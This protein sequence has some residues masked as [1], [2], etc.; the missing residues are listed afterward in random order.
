MKKFYK[1]LL[2]ISS[3]GLLTSCILSPGKKTSNEPSTTT[4]SQPTES[5][6]TTTTQDSRKKYEFHT[7]KSYLPFDNYGIHVS[8][9]ASGYENRD[10]IKDAINH[11]VGF[12]LVNSISA[13]DCTILTDDGTK[14]QEHLH[15]CVGTGSTDGGI[16]FNVSIQV[17]KIVVTVIPYYKTPYTVDTDATIYIDNDKFK[18]EVDSES[19]TQIESMYEKT[20]DTSVSSFTLSNKAEKQRFYLESVTL[21]Y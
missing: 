5:T 17:T 9:E 6:S 16:T 8:D 20:Y 10:A 13:H 3:L 2:L 15:L 14:N 11:E 12:G 4:S 18:I 21:Y 1:Y 7:S 19:D